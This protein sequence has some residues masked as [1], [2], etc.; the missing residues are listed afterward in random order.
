MS[1]PEPMLVRE[2][3]YFY[4]YSGLRK[5]K[6]Y[7]YKFECYAKGRWFGSKLLDVFKKEFRLESAEYYVSI[8]SDL[9]SS[10]SSSP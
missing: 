3:F 5:I 10:S 4:V 1:E 9:L 7:V 8:M 6:P 2:L